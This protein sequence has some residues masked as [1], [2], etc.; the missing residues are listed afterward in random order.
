MSNR[1]SRSYMGPQIPIVTTYEQEPEVPR[2]KRS[3][4]RA[5]NRDYEASHRDYEDAQALGRSP[6]RVASVRAT[7]PNF[8]RS[9]SRA[10]SYIK[11]D[12]AQSIRN[13]EQ[14]IPRSASR[15]GS[16]NHDRETIPRSAS[17]AGS[18]N[19]D[20][21]RPQSRIGNAIGAGV[22]AGGGAAVVGEIVSHDRQR[23]LQQHERPRSVSLHDDQDN[24]S[25]NQAL[26]PN[27][28]QSSFGHRPQPNLMTVA[29]D[30]R[31]SRYEGGRDSRAGVLGRSGTVMSRANTLGRNGTLS[32]AANGG[33]VGSRRGAFGRGAGA[34]IGTQPEEV[35]GRE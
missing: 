16:V 2:Q 30:G 11:A 22:G 13:V 15:A 23:S 6:S 14:P 34:S 5:S 24:R 8:A 25:A 33:T 9:P 18:I 28:P 29:E 12:K 31:E 32:R 1:V 17:R 7:D 26:S 27:R 20:R 4:S 35:L 21:E 10:A 3:S 19:Q